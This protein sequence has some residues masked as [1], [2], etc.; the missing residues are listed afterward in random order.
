MRYSTVP[1]D[2]GHWTDWYCPANA[3]RG[4]LEF[5]RLIRDVPYGVAEAPLEAATD[6]FD[7]LLDAL[8]PA[9]RRA[10]Q[11]GATTTHLHILAASLRRGQG[12]QLNLFRSAGEVG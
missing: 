5:D 4:R 6:R 10:Y 11:P 8:R 3:L 12:E 2:V 9:L 7:L 1:E